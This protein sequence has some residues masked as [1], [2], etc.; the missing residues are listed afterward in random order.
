MTG[1]S[2]PYEPHPYV[3]GR[4]A[5]L[6][7]LA[8][9][10]M[11]W[12]GAPRV[13]LLTGSPGTG[14][15]RLVTGFLM[16]C[17]PA[18]RAEL[19]LDALDPATVPPDLPPLTAL[20]PDGLTGTRLLA[21]L[22]EQLGL[23]STRVADVC[24]EL[25]AREGSL[26][27]VV[28]DVDRAGPVGPAEE[29]ARLVRE[30]LKPLADLPNLRLVAE[31]PRALATE[32]AQG[33]PPGAAQLIDLDE[34]RWADAEGLV[35][36]AETLLD[37]G[38]SGGARAVPFTVDPAA[39]RALAEA[40]VAR[41]GTGGGSRLT[42]RLAVNSLLA[43]A[44]RFDPADPNALPT[45]VAAA[46]DLHAHRAGADPATLRAI[47]APLALAEG[48]GLPVELLGPLASAVAGRD[49]HA[50]VAEGIALTAPFVETVELTG[51]DGVRQLLRLVHPG[52]G[53]AIQAG[54][55]DVRAVQT[56]IAM[57][58]LEEV[59]E[60]DWA[61]ADAY[62]R[63]H[64]A[65]HTLA[66]GLLPQLLTDPGLFTYADPVCLRAAVESVPPDSLGAAARTYL[67]TAPQLTAGRVPPQRR[68][69]LLEA[70][71][72]ADGLTQHATALRQLATQ[73]D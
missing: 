49:M 3:G 30:V 73:A 56:R 53:D 47:L 42:V 52:V 62:V 41:T 19:P 43:Q 72:T 26:A 65:S 34:E 24:A 7:A 23:R 63:D 4:N 68:A 35:R 45:G 48:M 12:P 8:A 28:P 14:C 50:T 46:L 31:V 33:L 51:E 11:E 69:E 54:F 2:Q 39:R 36:Q 66:A 60:Q 15:S 10:R 59:P 61:K 1:S 40:I 27:L 37:P 55:D 32:L 22:A 70:A 9:W 58:L 57:A 25:G 13:V 67:R 16:L 29:P 17:D 5:A 44:D 18:H 64:I 38:V 71:F 6:R 21:D 20:S